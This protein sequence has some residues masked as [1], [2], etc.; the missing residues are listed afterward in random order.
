[1]KHNFFIIN[2]GN[3]EIVQFRSGH[4]LQNACHKNVMKLGHKVIKEK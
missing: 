3:S 4:L 1:M 2:F